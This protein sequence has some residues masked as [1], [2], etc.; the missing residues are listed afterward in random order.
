MFS[1]IK[2]ILYFLVLNVVINA[3][4]RINPILGYI[5]YFGLIAYWFSGFRFKTRQFRSTTPNYE[6]PKPKVSGDVIDVEFTERE[7]N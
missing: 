1:L 3:I 6:R 4:F 7:E 2:Y 5:I